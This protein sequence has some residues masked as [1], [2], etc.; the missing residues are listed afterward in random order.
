MWLLWLLW[1][2]KCGVVCVVWLAW[3]GIYWLGLCGVAGV[4][5]CLFVSV[6]H[7]SLSLGS[8]TAEA[9]V[10]VLSYWLAVMVHTYNG[11]IW[12]A[13]TRGSETQ[14]PSA[15]KGALSPGYRTSCLSVRCA[16]TPSIPGSKHAGSDL[17]LSGLTSHKTSNSECGS[18]RHIF[19]YC[20]FLLETESHSVAQMASMWAP[21]ALDSQMLGLETSASTLGIRIQFWLW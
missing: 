10:P 1:C 3:C 8:S 21:S 19:I 2:H 14:S 7:H 5:V 11:C 20:I 6:P 13:G 15:T 9:R 18:Q 17:G 4:V 16:T 12:K